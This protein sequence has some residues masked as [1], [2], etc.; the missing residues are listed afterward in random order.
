MFK[1]EIEE[2]LKA[3]DKQKD[4][5]LKELSK[6]KEIKLNELESKAIKALQKEIDKKTSDN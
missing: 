3:M 4:E 1:K 6:K 5:T 2:L